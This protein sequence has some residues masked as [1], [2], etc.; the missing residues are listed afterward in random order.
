LHPKDAACIDNLGVALVSQGEYEAGIAHYLKAIEMN[1]DLPL[2]RMHLASA[3]LQVDTREALKWCRDWVQFSPR[4]PGAHHFLGHL[5]L[6]QGALEEGS[7][8]LRKSLE[9]A[10]LL[11]LPR[12]DLGRALARQGQFVES[13]A[14]LQ[15]AHDAPIRSP[16]GRSLVSEE[17]LR[18]AH[19]KVELDALLPYVQR[20]ELQPKTPEERIEFGQVAKLKRLY[21]T[22]ARLYEKALGDKPQL[23]DAGGHGY[24]AAC[25]AALAGWGQGEDASELTDADRRYWRMAALAW[26]QAEVAKVTKRLADGGEDRAKV[27]QLLRHWQIDADL[28]GVR[29]E[30]GLEK[31]PEEERGPW[32]QLWS[33]VRGLVGT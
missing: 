30:A 2:V 27:E 21:A 3:Y 25:Y 20:G 13:L 33:E 8:A 4:D 10:P 14:A 22:A 16:D 7:A 29:D 26:M 11:A 12:V 18:D 19:R 15:F 17:A 23:A 31:L 1:P 5:L 6:Q 9:L 24:D 32:R 28:S